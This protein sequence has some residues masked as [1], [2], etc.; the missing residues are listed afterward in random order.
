MALTITSQPGISSCIPIIFLGNRLFVR[1]HHKSHLKFYWTFPWTRSIKN[2]ST[3]TGGWRR[4]RPSLSPTIRT[5]R[6]GRWFLTLSDGQSPCNIF[7]IS[8]KVLLVVLLKGFYFFYEIPTTEE[9]STW[10]GPSVSLLVVGSKSYFQQ[11]PR[12]RSSAR[13]MNLWPGK[14]QWV[15]DEIILYGIST[16]PGAPSINIL[17]HSH[18]LEPQFNPQCMTTRTSHLFTYLLLSVYL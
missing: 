2:F 9:E 6:N 10:N 7:P 15:A 14:I 1:S 18:Q 4:R 13:T 3:R 17:M 16:L 12:H 5:R 11:K 8:P